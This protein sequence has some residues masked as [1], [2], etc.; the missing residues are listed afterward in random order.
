M[1]LASVPLIFQNCSNIFIAN[2]DEKYAKCTIPKGED[3]CNLLKELHRA[4]EFRTYFLAVLPI[5]LS[6]IAFLL[7]ITYF[8]ILIRCFISDDNNYRKRYVFLMSRTV[9]IL[10]ANVLLYVVVIVWKSDGFV[11]TSAMIFI[12]LGALNFLSVT[13]TYIGLTTLLYTAITHNFWYRYSLRLK[14]CVA[15]VALMWLLSAASSICVGLW[16]ATLFYPDSAPVSCELETCQRPLA[17][18][19][20]V[21]LA[22]CY[23]TVLGLYV[24]MMIR[25]HLITR[26]STFVKTKSATNNMTA[27]KRLGLNMLTFA[28]GT[29][30]I[31]I[32]CIVAVSNLGELAFLGEGDKT[33]CKSFTNSP[34]FVEVEIL[35]SVAAIFRLIAMIIDPVINTLADQK[36]SRMFKNGA[37]RLGRSIKSLRTLST[38]RTKVQSTAENE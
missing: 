8:V 4:K 26:N 14:H 6:V 37:V 23:S 29:I 1:N 22:L 12:F 7:N 36:M 33:P 16:G 5:V 28:V 15:G 24:L 10:L 11:Y 25:L 2:K 13:G 35:A 21:C 20:V 31:L 27:I 34:L 9:S 19:I 17:I 3:A 32:V 38:Q 18:C 30:P